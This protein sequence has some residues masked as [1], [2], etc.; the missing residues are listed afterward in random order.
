MTTFEKLKAIVLEQTQDRSLPVEIDSRFKEDL[1]FSSLQQ[2]RLITAVESA[3]GITLQTED[4]KESNFISVL[5][6]V[7]MLEANYAV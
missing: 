2:I 7:K 4:F 3:F 5:T 1:A 6:L